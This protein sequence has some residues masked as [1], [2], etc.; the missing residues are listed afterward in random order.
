MCEF[1]ECTHIYWYLYTCCL[2]FSLCILTDC[3]II[4]SISIRFQDQLSL[5]P[6]H[7]VFKCCVVCHVFCSTCLHTTFQI[8]H[9]WDISISN[10][11]NFFLFRFTPITKCVS[12]LCW[13]VPGMSNFIGRKSTFGEQK[14][15]KRDYARPRHIDTDRKWFRRRSRSSNTNRNSTM[16]I[17]SGN[18]Q[19]FHVFLRG[20]N[21]RMINRNEQTTKMLYLWSVVLLPSDIACSVSMAF[22]YRFGVQLD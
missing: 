11:S 16:A 3:T 19:N 12:I 20:N 18:W 17:D 15:V 4:G 13:F 1:S 10:I 5:Q 7:D 9:I 14:W 22:R 8:S 21:K 2:V 6:N